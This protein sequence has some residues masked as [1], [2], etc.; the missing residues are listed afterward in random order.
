[1]KQ[2]HKLLLDILMGA[3]IP[4]LILNYLSKRLGAPTAYVTAALIPVAWVAIDLFFI[5][6]RFNMITVITG[7]NAM[8]SGALAFWFVDGVRYALKDSAALIV[9]VLIFGGSVIAGRPVLQAFF[10]QIVNPDTPEREQALARLLG[11][12]NVRRALT[13]GTLIVTVQSSVSTA[14]N[15]LLN[16]QIVHATFGSEE[17]NQQVASVNAITRVVFPILSLLAFF[18]AIWMTY[19]AIFMR[20][21]SEEGKH[22]ME[23]NFWTLVELWE[24]EPSAERASVQAT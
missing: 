15:F 18:A 12:P 22:Q 14:I 5:T 10:R 3:V 17:F 4:I 20:L 24:Q 8:V 1:M 9:S 19:R 21:P 7:L 13:I 16:L 11:E 2:S 6:R 23:S